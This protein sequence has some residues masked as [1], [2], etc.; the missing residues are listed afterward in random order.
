M[1][2]KK[3]ADDQEK[4]NRELLPAF[5]ST[6]ASRSDSTISYDDMHELVKR[7]MKE[8]RVK[9]YVKDPASL[10]NLNENNWEDWMLTY[11]YI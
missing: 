4:K 2:M 7:Y 9:F 6:A 8:P 5:N 3:T 11:K 10:L 1:R